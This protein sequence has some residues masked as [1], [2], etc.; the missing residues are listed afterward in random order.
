MNLKKLAIP[1]MTVA[2]AACAGVPE[3][4]DR[5][6]SARTT[7]NAV[8]ADATI[9]KNAPAELDRAAK[10]LAQADAA[11]TARHDSIETDHL[12]YLASQRAET[13]RQ[14]GLMRTNE[15]RIEQS[16]VERD[17][18]RL[19][20]RTVEAQRA[21]V[22]AQTAQTEANRARANADASKA[23]ADAARAQTDVARRDTEEAQRIAAVSQA[24]AQS[25]R[26]RAQ[27]I[28]QQLSE[29]AAKQT[30]R[31]MVVTLQ[32]VVFE[33]GRAE[34]QPG[35]LRAVERMAAVL[36][37][38]PAR[39]VMIEGFT[40]STGSS[41][42]NIA[43]SERRADAVRLALLSRGVA[44]DRVNVRGLG[45]S[46]PVATNATPEG[47]QLNRRVE[48]IFSDDKGAIGAR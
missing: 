31:G 36:V 39:R 2:I 42:S 13:A 7:V 8:S 1:V 3:R 19:D 48:L 18:V 15:Q 29:L 47:R 43:L 12:A 37:D 35:A 28:E 25:E 34:L 33:V 10:T 17:R 6:E 4:N 22:Q 32:D 27:R 24:S 41:D 11:W 26:E 40:D 38:N 5:L 46:Y 16:Q 9:A 44:N 30:P 20:A 45:P 21:T 23:S 14:V